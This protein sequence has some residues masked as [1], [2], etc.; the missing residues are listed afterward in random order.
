MLEVRI[1]VKDGTGEH[2]VS[3]VQI[4]RGEAHTRLPGAFWYQYRATIDQQDTGSKVQFMGK[5]LHSYK[6]GAVALT[7]KVTKAILAQQKATRKSGAK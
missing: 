7:Q 2:G 3:I 6:N 5:V 4:V 1:S